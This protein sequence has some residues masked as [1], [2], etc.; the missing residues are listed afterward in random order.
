MSWGEDYGPVMSMVPPRRRRRRRPAPVG[1]FLLIGMI[2][3]LALWRVETVG[4]RMEARPP[5][6]SRTIGLALPAGGGL[7]VRFLGWE[8]GGESGG[9]T[10]WKTP[11]RIREGVQELW[12]WVREQ[13]GRL[14]SEHLPPQP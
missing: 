12:Q 8:W 14:R 6:P 7:Q 2:A 11:S 3:L 10:A 4:A 9:T 13:G 5:G 1:R